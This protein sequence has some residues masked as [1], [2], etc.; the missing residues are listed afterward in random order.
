M[1]I[2]ISLLLEVSLDH[3]ITVGI[4]ELVFTYLTRISSLNPKSRHY[5]ALGHVMSCP[6]QA[7]QSNYI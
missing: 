4:D 6:G 2:D 7:N 1:C 5:V 3:S